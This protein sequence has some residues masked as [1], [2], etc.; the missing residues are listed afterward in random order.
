MFFI[1]PN[2]T[3]TFGN[4]L[5][6]F[7]GDSILVSP[8]TEENSTSVEIYLPEDRFYAWKT[9]EIVEGKGENITLNDIAFTEI[10]LHIRGGSII[11][12]RKESG[13]TTAATRKFPFE[14]IIAPDSDGKAKGSLYLDDGDS[15][16]QAG[17]SEIT[18]TFEDGL[19]SVD[20]TFGYTGEEFRISGVT[21][22]G[23]ETAHGAPSYQHHSGKK[24]SAEAWTA[25][26]DDAW[27]EDLTKGVTVAQLD[28]LLTGEFSVHF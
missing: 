9:W 25:V 27:S 4:D 11:P 22:L 19:L 14:I 7:Y 8:V 13:M 1:Y 23:C 15:I 6:F 2:D 18:F 24:R 28:E 10:P 3:N 5:Q 20:G 26:A 17:T 12:V 21:L 16:E